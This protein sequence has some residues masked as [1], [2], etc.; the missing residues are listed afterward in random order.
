MYMTNIHTF[1]RVAYCG[2]LTQAA[3]ELFVSQPTVT[4]RLQQ[5]EEEVGAVLIRRGK[6]VRA[7]ELTPQGKAFLPLAE[8]WAALDAE[9]CQFRDQKMQ[10][11]LSVACLDSVSRYILAPLFRDVTRQHPN[12]RLNIRTHQSHEIFSLVEGREV[13]LGFSYML[14][15]YDH[16]IC[17]PLF[18]EPMVLV[19]AKDSLP[20]GPVDLARL[21]SALEIYVPWS[22][23]FRLWHND[24]WNPKTM[25]LVQADLASMIPV[26][27]DHPG[28]WAICPISAARAFQEADCAMEIREPA[29]P[30]PGRTCYLL[31]NRG[32]DEP[33]TEAVLLFRAALEAFLERASW[34]K[35]VETG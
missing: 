21:D 4:A 28:S 10:L 35:A 3:N 33:E 20:E 18:S 23:E 30:T 13:D 9:T 15:H 1:L 5:L 12:L 26:Y 11:P 25:P 7:L 27:L 8:R 31:S 24:W 16:V 29:Q 14:S 19:A 34:L 6:G 32:K 22:R 2:S 17:R